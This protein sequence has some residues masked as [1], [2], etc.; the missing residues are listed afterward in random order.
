MNNELEKL[1]RQT[2]EEVNY[3]N[4]VLT[5]ILIILIL[6]V[7]AIIYYILKKEGIIK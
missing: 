7:I 5:I 4:I 1:N 2:K 3:S 6:I